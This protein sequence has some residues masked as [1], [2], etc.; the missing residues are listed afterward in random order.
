MV[1]FVQKTLLSTISYKMY[2]HV[3]SLEEEVEYFAAYVNV[4]SD[5]I[6][7]CKQKQPNGCEI[8]LKIAYSALVAPFYINR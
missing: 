2:Q 6:E 3:E 8:S 5:T 4:S 1:P 7:L